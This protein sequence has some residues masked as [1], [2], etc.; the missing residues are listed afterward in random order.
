MRKTAQKNILFFQNSILPANG[1]VPRVSD[2][3]ATQ[4]T[5]RGYKCYFVYYDKDNAAYADDIKLKVNFKGNYQH[6]EAAVLQF[7]KK[8]DID[9]FVCQN[10]YF[11][12]FIRLFKQIRLLYP[13]QLFLCFLHASPDYWQL[14][15]KTRYDWFSPKFLTNTLK[16]TVKKIIYPFYNPYIATT[17]ALYQICDRFI[18]L[19]DSFKQPFI[20]LYGTPGVNSK[21]LTIP[22]PLTFDS[23]ITPDELAGKQKVVLIIS[24]LDESQK[25]ISVALKIWKQLSPEHHHNWKLFIVGSGPDEGL[26]KKYVIDHQLS[27]VRFFGQQTDVIGYYKQASVF[28]MTSVWEGLPMSLLE[29]QQN[30]VVPIAFNNF[31]AIYDAVTDGENGYI[32]PGN[33]IND[34]TDKL[35]GLMEHTDL[36]RRMALT[37]VES[38]KRYHVTCIADQWEAVLNANG[39]KNP[40]QNLT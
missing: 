27:N 5:S 19:S 10:T 25:K 6:F 29:A 32:I 3:I 30:G 38:S 11:T 8:N 33:N 4:L 15:Y 17:A 13:A 26:Y 22:N 21:L 36:R 1:G 18:L 23:Y 37:S 7:I 28:M 12:S 16:K 24:R 40:I 31:S 35:S 20:K 39:Q 14:T 34:F 9:V 2:I